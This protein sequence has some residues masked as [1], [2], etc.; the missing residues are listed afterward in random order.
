[1]TTIRVQHAKN[2][3]CISNQ[4][5]RDKSLSLKARGLHHLLL[6]YP[7]G[8][9][10]SIDHLLAESDKDGKKAIAAGLKELETAGYLTRTRIR[11]SQTGRLGWECVIRELPISP[12]GGDGQ[13]SPIS[14]LLPDSDDATITPLPSDG[15]P[16]DGD[17]SDGDP[18]DGNG[19]HIL[20]TDLESTDLRSTELESTDLKKSLSPHKP[21]LQKRE[22]KTELFDEDGQPIEGYRQWLIRRMDQLPQKVGIPELWIEK[23]A[24]KQSLQK[25]FLKTQERSIRT[26]VPPPLPPL[27]ENSLEPQ[28]MTPQARLEKYRVLWATPLLRDGIKRQIEAHPEWGL[29]LGEAGPQLRA[30]GVTRD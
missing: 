24:K 5:I 20:S 12:F 13:N 4:A 28:E 15:D 27:V 6:S 22:M 10:I 17:P 1:M 25:A 29:E 11:D 23:N 26:T 7:D 19:G 18:S 21:L 8:W 2:Y 16:S 9:R 3:T 14:D 30:G